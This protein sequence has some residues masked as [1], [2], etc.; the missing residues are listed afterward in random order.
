MSESSGKDQEH[1]LWRSD[2]T[3]VDS[4]LVGEATDFNLCELARLKIRYQGFPGAR[5]IQRDLEKALQR[6]QL[7][8]ASLFE[9]TREIHQRGGIYQGRNK[10]QDDWS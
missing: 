10:D 5:D 9:R 6:W 1:P 8:E 7:D 4:L 3:T 2:R